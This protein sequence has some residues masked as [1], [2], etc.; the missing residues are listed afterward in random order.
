MRLLFAH[1]AYAKPSG[2]EQAVREIGDLVTRQGHQVDW[3]RRSSADIPPGWGQI[4]A[5]FS[6]IHSRKAAQAM[7]AQLRSVG[8]DLVQ[9]QNLYPL[10]SPSILTACRRAGVPVVMRCPNYRLF[11]PTGLHLSHGEICEKCCGGREWW[12]TIKNCD[13]GGNRLRSFSY[14]VRALT[15][16]WSRAIL[17]QVDRFVVLTEFQRQRFIQGGIPAERIDVIPNLAAPLNPRPQASRPIAD[18]PPIANI[19]DPTGRGD[20]VTFVGRVSAEKG[21]ED[22]VAAARALP[23]L[24]FAVA[25]DYGAMPELVAAAP[26]NVQ[27][28]GFLSAEPLDQVYA[29]SRI[30]VFPS[31]WFEG[32]PNVITRAML[33]GKPIIAARIGGLPEI[34]EHD[35]SGFLFPPRDTHEL[36]SAIRS[37]YQDLNK[38][39]TLGEA[40][41]RKASTDY[42]PTAVAAKWL[43]TYRLATGNR[44]R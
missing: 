22:F 7:K 21:I 17:G 14:S 33:H 16:R 25:G 11:C 4:S 19:P 24:P 32:F 28:L 23:D 44:Q 20:L 18:G 6:G 35:S 15:A 27:W 39:R 34:V 8:Y 43:D 37:L 31:R 41:L 2:E 29:R 40:G 26:P 30:L 10:L 3:F 5:F 9:V 1:N 13:I 12:C 42:G 38:C 36:V